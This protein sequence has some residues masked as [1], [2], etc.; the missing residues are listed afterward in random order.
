M[1]P[2]LVVVEVVQ[3][4]MLEM[5]VQVVVDIIM[6]ILEG[7]ELVIH[8]QVV[9]HLHHPLMVGEITEQITILDLAVA[10]EAVVLEAPEDKIQVHHLLV[11]D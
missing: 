8:S 10:V 4:I 2:P 3:L 6:A 7:L 1:S 11:V 5:V 9:L